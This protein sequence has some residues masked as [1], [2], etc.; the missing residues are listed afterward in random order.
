MF[1]ARRST[2]TGH[3]MTHSTPLRLYLKSTT[4][5][6]PLEH[7]WHQRELHGQDT[8]HVN[9]IKGKWRSDLTLL[10]KRYPSY[11]LELST[12][13]AGS[14]MTT[15]HNLEVEQVQAITKGIGV[16]Y[17]A[18]AATATTTLVVG[19]ALGFRGGRRY[20]LNRIRKQQQKPLALS[21]LN[22]TKLSRFSQVFQRAIVRPSRA[23][24]PLQAN[25]DT[26]Q[27]TKQELT[28]NALEAVGVVEAPKPVIK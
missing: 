26:K 4:W 9:C 7:L 27:D 28:L 15:V 21:K 5:F 1:G 11:F 10:S 6:S 19:Y 24:D 12:T 18:C 2:V 20:T 23:T 22:V 8:R 3:C 13:F 16:S 25:C 17:P 14:Q